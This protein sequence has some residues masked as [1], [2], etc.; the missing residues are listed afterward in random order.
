[1]R[2]ITPGNASAALLLL[3]VLLNSVPTVSGQQLDTLV[4]RFH[5]TDE[6]LNNPG[7]GFTTFQRFNGDELNPG[8]GWTEGFP[9]EHQEF[10]GNLENEAY[11]Q[12]TIAYDR[13]YAQ[14]GEAELEEHD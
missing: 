14:Y 6:L 5:D 10:D 9:I 12:T 3:M 1:M 13:V 11:P 2:H 4:V 7:K 8:A